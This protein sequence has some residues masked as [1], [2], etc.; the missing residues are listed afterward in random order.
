MT[1]AIERWLDNR[2]INPFRSFSQIQDPIDRVFADLLT[3][4]KA[5]GN[6]LDT[7]FLSPY[8]EVSEDNKHYTFKFD[9]PG[10][11]KDQIKIEIDGN[12]MT[13]S[14]ERQEEKRSDSKKKLISELSYGFLTR[15]FSLPEPVDEKKIDAKFEHGVL[16]VMVPKSE[17]HKRKQIAI[18]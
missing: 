1:N 10:V 4:R 8:C 18:N 11:S 6:A 3:S 16:T 2:N 13:I 5:N 9:L 12:Q 14:A 15:S 7:L 17:S